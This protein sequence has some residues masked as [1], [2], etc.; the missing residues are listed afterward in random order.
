MIYCL[1]GGGIAG[2]PAQLGLAE[3]RVDAVT[4]PESWHVSRTLRALELLAFGP[5]SAVEVAEAAGI[6][7]RTARRLLH[8]LIDEGY[9]RRLPAQRAGYAATLRLLAVAGHLAEH[10]ALTQ[11]SR[12]YVARLRDQTDYTT[13]LAVPSYRSVL[14]IVQ[15]PGAGPAASAVRFGEQLPCHAT[16]LGKALLAH[17]PRWQDDV[18]S[19]PLQA[20]TERTI[21]SVERLRGELEKVREHGVAVGRGEF[22]ADVSALAA[23]IFDDTGTAI[24]ALGIAVPHGQLTQDRL[25]QLADVVTSHAAS[26]SSALAGERASG[27]EHPGP[28]PSTSQENGQDGAAPIGAGRAQPI[29]SRVSAADAA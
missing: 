2:P 19:Q 24:A 16:A 9:V 13:R 7:E 4:A 3:D 23:P 10:S 12:P 22:R 15:E 20:E 27:G 5:R 17:R 1:H 11:T 6:H 26:I 21:T 14:I 25:P 29:V 28:S 8:R 18:L